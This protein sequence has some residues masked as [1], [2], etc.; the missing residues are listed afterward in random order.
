MLFGLLTILLMRKE[1]IPIK[2]L[3]SPNK[4]ESVMDKVKIILVYPTICFLVAMVCFLSAEYIRGIVNIPW[5][6]KT[7]YDPM[8]LGPIYGIFIVAIVL[9]SICDEFYFRGYLINLLSK[10][11]YDE[12]R[13][14]QIQAVL[15]SLWHWFFG[16]IAGIPFTLLM[17]YLFG[18][19]YLKNRDFYAVLLGHFVLNFLLGGYYMVTHGL[20]S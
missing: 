14:V 9:P 6:T 8:G 2:S 19:H 16:L 10:L 13:I 17:G 15:F 4:S 20:Q 3:H 18:K 5:L 12:N 7:N 1:K 11:N